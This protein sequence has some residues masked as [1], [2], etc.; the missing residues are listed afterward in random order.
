MMVAGD[1]TNVSSNVSNIIEY[2]MIS[3]RDRWCKTIEMTLRLNDELKYHDFCV[4]Y[5]SGDVR[6]QSNC[7]ILGVIWLKNG[8]TR[9]MRKSSQN[10]G[11]RGVLP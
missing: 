11:S 3:K 8:K 10:E 5:Q 7:T 4:I 2:T 9:K 1:E 6:F